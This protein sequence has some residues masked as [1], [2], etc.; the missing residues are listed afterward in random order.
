MGV[1]QSMTVKKKPSPSA[2]AV[3][4]DVSLDGAW[5]PLLTVLTA[6]YLGVW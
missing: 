3:S 5:F 4:L 2:S 6:M 1:D